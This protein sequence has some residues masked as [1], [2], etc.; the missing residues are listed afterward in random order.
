[1]NNKSFYALVGFTAIIDLI[2]VIR[3]IEYGLLA[4]RAILCGGTLYYIISIMKAKKKINFFVPFMVLFA[5]LYNPVV[6]IPL[7][8]WAWLLLDMISLATFY[9]L[10]QS[11]TLPGGVVYKELFP[12]EEEKEKP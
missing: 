10:S 5:V 12:D 9:L 3:P 7:P 2:F 8:V 11:A 6:P 1:M 4:T